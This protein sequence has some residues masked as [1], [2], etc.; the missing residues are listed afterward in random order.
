MDKDLQRLLVKIIKQPSGC[1]EF[2]G[3]PINRDGHKYFYCRGKHASAHR[4]SYILHKGDLEDGLVVRHTCDNPGC[5]N[6][7]HLIPGTH[8]DNMHDEATRGGPSKRNKHGVRGL[9]QQTATGY[10]H[11]NIR[12]N[13]KIYQLVRKD[14]QEVIQWLET[15][16]A[17]LYPKEKQ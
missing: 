9:S 16:R 10:W 13:G 2:Q 12:K 14:K 8:A 5:V 17:T 3:A 11:G 1:W 6:P 7:D 4:S 15:T